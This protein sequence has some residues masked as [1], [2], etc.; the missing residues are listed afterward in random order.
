MNVGTHFY[1]NANKNALSEIVIRGC[2]R[3]GEREK[4]ETSCLVL[5]P[6]AFL[7]QQLVLVR[8]VPPGASGIP[9][10]ISVS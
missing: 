1:L 8:K 4:E 2:G 9:L 7:S 3:V 10:P 5:P 6:P